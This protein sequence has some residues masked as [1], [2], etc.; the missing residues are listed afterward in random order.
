MHHLL[1]NTP[2]GSVML[3]AVALSSI[4]IVYAVFIGIGRAWER[5]QARVRVRRLR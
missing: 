1:F 2:E 5:H 3:A 4:A